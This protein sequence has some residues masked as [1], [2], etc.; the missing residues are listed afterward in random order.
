MP[1]QQFNS[2]NRAPEAAWYRVFGLILESSF[3]TRAFFPRQTVNIL[4]FRL[5]LCRHTVLTLA[6]RATVCLGCY[7]GSVNNTHTPSLH[8]PHYILLVGHRL[9]I[10]L[11][12]QPVLPRPQPRML[13]KLFGSQPLSRVDLH[14]GFEEGR[15]HFPGLQIQTRQEP[16]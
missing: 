7:L 14:R 13:D 15:K 2:Y 8:G 16:L 1:T 10:N 5:R 4:L 12:G 3:V 11:P 6:A 9:R